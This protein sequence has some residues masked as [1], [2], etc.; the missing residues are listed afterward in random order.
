MCLFHMCVSAL[1]KQLQHLE[2]FANMLRART[3]PVFSFP[4]LVVSSCLHSK[5]LKTSGIGCER[6]DLSKHSCACNQTNNASPLVAHTII[7][8]RATRPT[9]RCNTWPKKKNA[10][11]QP[12]ERTNKPMHANTVFLQ[13]GDTNKLARAARSRMCCR[14]W[15][16][17]TFL[18]V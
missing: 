15:T 9:V 5:Y 2:T 12:G 18:R 8:A 11:V 14:T 4:S 3:L 13:T 7:L 6:M 17:E 10:R 16:T 1:A